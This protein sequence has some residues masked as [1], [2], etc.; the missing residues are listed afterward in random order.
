MCGGEEDEVAGVEGVEGGLL[1]WGGR[2]GCGGEEGRHCVVY[3][4]VCVGS[5]EEREERE[6]RCG[7]V[8][9]WFHRM[10]CFIE[11]QAVAS[12]IL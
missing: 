3:L 10:G 1:G 11:W 8:S 2:W 9:G 7:D 12:D 4:C 6:D 5:R